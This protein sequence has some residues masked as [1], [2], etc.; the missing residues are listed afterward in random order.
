M[1]DDQPARMVQHWGDC[2]D[3]RERD[4]ALAGRRRSRRTAAVLLMAAVAAGAF[5]GRSIET[6]WTNANAE[7]LAISE[8]RRGM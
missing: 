7:A 3:A 1:P 5:A 6:I 4:E 8:Y 2:N